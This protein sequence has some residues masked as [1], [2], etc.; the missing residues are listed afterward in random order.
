MRKT[1]TLAGAIVLVGVDQSSKIL[2]ES[3]LDSDPGIEP[4][5]WIPGIV[6]LKLMA[7]PGG[8]GGLL[9]QLP[10]WVFIL[11]TFAVVAFV[12]LLISRLDARQSHQLPA[13]GLLLAGFTGN[14]IDR[15]RNG[16]VTDFIHIPFLP[17]R[18]VSR[19]NIADVCILL[20][21]GALVC[22]Y[23]WSAKQPRQDS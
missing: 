18:I 8:F 10:P 7:N 20:G 9:S 6:D 16:F 12:G 13:L 22:G 1:L 4:V 21:L 11:L 2:A 19:F 17:E 5:P 23:L 14:G 3:L 15:I